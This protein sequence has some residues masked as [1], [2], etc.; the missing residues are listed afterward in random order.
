MMA[1]VKT[2]FPLD[3]H[4]SIQLIK[5]ILS[6]LHSLDDHRLLAILHILF[7]PLAR[8]KG[9]DL[10]A[11]LDLLADCYHALPV[12]LR[13][14]GKLVLDVHGIG[15]GGHEKHEDPGRPIYVAMLLDELVNRPRR[16]LEAALA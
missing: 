1:F 7:P 9:L 11:F 4:E 3:P 13:Q 2:T 10:G 15:G 14:R 8:A 5:G 6:E 12:G 16:S